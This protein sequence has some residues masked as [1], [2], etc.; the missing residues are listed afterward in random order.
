[1][2]ETVTI[3]KAAEH[4]EPSLEEQAAAV[5]IDTSKIDVSANEQTGEKPVA[6][7][8]KKILGKFN[9]QEDLEKAY[10]ELEKKLG[11]GEKTEDKP[12]A[13]SNEPEV[14]TEVEPEAPTEEQVKETVENAGLN[15]EELSAKFW[16]KGALD[17][18]DYEALEKSGIPKD[19]VKAF[20]AGQQAILELETAK[21]HAIAGGEDG[22]K[23]MVQWAAT[24]LD[25]AEIAAYDKAVNS[26]D[27]NIVKAAV[28]G[29]KARA[30]AERGFE[31]VRQVGGNTRGSRGDVYNSIA[32]MQEDMRNPKYQ[33][34]PAFRAGVEQKLGRSNIL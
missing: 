17:E 16:D 27:M 10:Q 34:D 8:A 15:F 11:S 22:Y 7:E 1:M 14:E 23:E 26:D 24:A 12:E 18:T 6:P 29:L 19:Y 2:V 31:P 33:N 28:K 13:E 21:V 32:E 9:S 5:G 4:V 3:N 20:E 30:D 25:A